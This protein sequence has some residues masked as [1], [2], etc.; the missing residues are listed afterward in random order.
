MKRCF[1]LV[2]SLMFVLT[3]AACGTEG[4]APASDPEPG[5]PSSS[6]PEVIPEP[7]PSEPSAQSPGDGSDPAPAADLPDDLTSVA[8]DFAV[9]FPYAFSSPEELQMERYCLL[10]I[11]YEDRGAITEDGQWSW[12]SRER[13]EEEVRR[14]FDL[15]D[16]RFQSP[17]QENVYPRYVEEKGAIAFSLAGGGPRYVAELTGQEAQGEYYDYIFDLYDNFITDGHE[18][19]TLE[20]TLRYRFRV[21]EGDD[22]AIYLQAV[23]AMEVGP[24]QPSQGEA[25]PESSPAGAEGEEALSQRSNAL[26]SEINAAF[27]GLSK[28]SYSYFTCYQ[29]NNA[30]VLEIGV[31]DE[32][33]VDAFL[34]AWTGTKWDTLLK[35]PGSASQAKQERF[36]EEAEKL[37]I[38]PNVDVHIT[39]RDGPA[40]TENGR[41]LISATVTN[42]KPWEDI[43]PE[44]KE[45]A[46]EMG[47][48]EYMIYYICHSDDGTVTNTTP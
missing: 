8:S 5:S 26:F 21:A 34:A 11:Y 25:A 42:R 41:I 45:L 37:A 30:V 6:A 12:I 44:I 23:S 29:E 15:P 43:P 20:T 31:T 36:A 38:G 16:Y 19:M 35:I 13:L 48:P 14:R 18:E 1:A 17:E 47:I 27:R 32:A 3:L 28:D 4:Q 24:A 39:A 10:R 7:P 9:N 2:L 40:Y 33:A 46:G 22:G